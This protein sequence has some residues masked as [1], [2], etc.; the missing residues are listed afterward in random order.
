MNVG[1]VFELLMGWAASNLDCRVRIVPFDEMHG[2]EKS[3]QTVETFLK[4]A[5]KQP[6]RVGCT[7]L[8]IPASCS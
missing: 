3:Q 1:Q 6:G 7:T 2:A 5:A 8:R 4:E